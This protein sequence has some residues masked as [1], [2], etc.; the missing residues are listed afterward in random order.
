MAKRKSKEWKEDIRKSL[1]GR[2]LSDEH[3][4][5]ISKAGK[6]VIH[7]PEWNKK[8]SEAL[9]G[10]K[11]S[12]ET[13]RKKRE[14]GKKIRGKT[15][16]EIHGKENAIKIKRKL[17]SLNKGKNN[18]M[19]GKTHTIDAR[20]KI[21]K[22]RKALKGKVKWKNH[23]GKNIPC[24]KCKKE[25]YVSKS[26]IDNNKNRKFFCSVKCK[27]NYFTMENSYLWRGGKSFEPY[28]RDFNNRFK[29]DIRKRDNQTCMICNIHRE[30]LKKALSIHHINYDKLLSIQ[31]NCISLCMSCHTK[32]NMNRKHWTKFLQSLLSEKYGY[33]YN[34]GNIV[35]DIEKID[36]KKI[37]NG[38]III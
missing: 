34:D 25:R 12:E 27:M 38:E 13:L 26:V 10:R 18:N 32:T 5:N 36:N 3:K 37:H 22:A 15:Y 1:I 35:F 2:K 33:N 31:E 21:S 30:K 14:N 8:V 23:T 6:N 24:T 11:F 4:A 20:N 17:S 29:N 16:E 7:T 28:N 9:K 19:Y